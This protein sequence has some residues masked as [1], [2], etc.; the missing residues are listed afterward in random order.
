MLIPKLIAIVS[1]AYNI[2]LFI[3]LIRI[4]LSWTNPNPWNPV[5]RWISRVT[6]PFLNFIRRLVPLQAG[7]FDFSPIIAILLLSVL[8]W[9]IISLLASF[10]G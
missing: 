3:F 8:R 10:M 9:I 7:M 1:L 5:V 2:Y 4:I 6:D